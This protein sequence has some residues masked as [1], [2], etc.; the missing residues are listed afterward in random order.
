MGQQASR[1]ELVNQGFLRRRQA[2]LLGMQGSIC[3]SRIADHLGT[4]NSWNNKQ[5]V[6]QC[7]KE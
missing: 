5:V 1:V 6:W 4:A 2:P 7:W 3:R